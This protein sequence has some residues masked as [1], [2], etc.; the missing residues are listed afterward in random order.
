M[1]RKTC[2]IP[3]PWKIGYFSQTILYFIWGSFIGFERTLMKAD[4]PKPT[5][6]EGP[7]SMSNSTWENCLTKPAYRSV[8]RD[9]KFEKSFSVMRRS[10]SITKASTKCGEVG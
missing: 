9:F 10:A 8:S 4:Y 6:V 7:Y 2:M 1:I 3:R 5:F